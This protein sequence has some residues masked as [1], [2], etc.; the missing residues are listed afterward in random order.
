MAPNRFRS[1]I[2]STLA[3]RTAL[4][5]AIAATGHTFGRGLMPRNTAGQAL[6]TGLTGSVNYGLLVTGQSALWAGASLLAPRLFPAEP[7]LD[8]ESLMVGHRNRVRALAYGT[9]GATYAASRPLQRTV[10]QRPGESV[11][12][13]VVRSTLQQMETASALGLVATGVSDVAYSAMTAAGW[14]RRTRRIA[15]NGRCWPSV[16]AWRRSWSTVSGSTRRW[17]RAGR[18]PP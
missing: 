12:R 15:G 17:P 8:D 5:A 10:A 11:A 14:G 3:E 2:A 1:E 6:A 4:L 9:Y 13:G 18:R 7:G 16:R